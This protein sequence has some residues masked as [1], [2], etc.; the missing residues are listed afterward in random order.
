M[1]SQGE[2]TALAVLVVYEQELQRAQAWRWLVAAL[3]DGA[4]PGIRLAH[5]LVYDNSRNPIAYAASDVERCSYVHDPDNGGTA[6]AYGRAVELAVERGIGWLL[7]I[8]Q[9]TELPQGF[10]DAAAAAL[11]NP[12]V[13]APAA[14]VPWVID[15]AKV[16]SPARVTLLGSIRPLRRGGALAHVPGLTAV[17]SG[18]LMRVAMLRQVLPFPRELWLDYVDHWLIARMNLCGARIAV[19]DAVLRHTL[20]IMRPGQLSDRRLDSILDGES[21]FQG[22]LGPLARLVYPFR[23]LGRAARYALISPRLAIHVLQWMIREGQRARA[24]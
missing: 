10:L 7:L 12:S 6:A 17:A 11:G 18:S 13:E 9:D 1:S 16:V 5:V 19:F 3:H 20:S 23:L 4:R 15:Q 24:D 2:I 21:Y 14:L 8:D 22:L